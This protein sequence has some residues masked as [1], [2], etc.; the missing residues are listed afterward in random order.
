MLRKKTVKVQESK[1]YGLGWLIG[2]KEVEK[3]IE[4]LVDD[5]SK[6]NSS[7]STVT[8]AFAAGVEAQKDAAILMDPLPDAK[9]PLEPFYKRLEEESAH[10][11]L[12]K[13]EWIKHKIHY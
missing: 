10:M 1:F 13:D 5:A 3:E 9:N 6:D 11:E 2:Y 12:L 7:T 4:E 8:S